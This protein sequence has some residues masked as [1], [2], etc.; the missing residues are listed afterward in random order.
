MLALVNGWEGRCEILN[1]GMRD[2]SLDMKII[3]L[4]IPKR[5]IVWVNS[6]EKMIALK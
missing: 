1:G 6:F 5:K 2:F 4:H 3:D